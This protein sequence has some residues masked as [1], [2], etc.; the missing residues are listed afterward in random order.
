MNDVPSA[1]T[2]IARVAP[3]G[4]GATYLTFISEY[5]AA[6]VTTLAIVYAVLQMVLRVMEHRAIMQ[7]AEKETKDVEGN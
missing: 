6:I 3:L 1:G 5:G 2:E 7:K 4:F